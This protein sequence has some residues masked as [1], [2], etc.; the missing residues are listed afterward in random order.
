MRKSLQGIPEANVPRVNVCYNMPPER[1]GMHSKE[2]F[3]DEYE[4]DGEFCSVGNW[5]DW[6]SFGSL[7]AA[8]CC[9]DSLLGSL[10]YGG[11]LEDWIQDR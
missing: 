1:F 4:G 10:V 9:R 2:E 5:Y 3:K 7:S 6:V 8:A 11:Q